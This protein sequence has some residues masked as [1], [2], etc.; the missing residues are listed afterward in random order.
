MGRLDP[1]GHE[2][3]LP[4]RFGPGLDRSAEGR[5][6]GYNVIRRRDQHQPVGV[7]LFKPERRGQHG[8]GSVAPL[9][10]DQ[11]RPGIDPRLGQLFGHDEAKVRVGQHQRRGK[12]LAREPFGRSLEQGGFPHQRHEL[13]GIGFTRQRPEPCPRATAEKNGRDHL[14]CLL[15]QGRHTGCISLYVFTS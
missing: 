2:L 14:V 4:G 5:R 9:G 11:D 15:P 10:F 13:L 12:A 1:E 8:G 6:I 7:A 3:L